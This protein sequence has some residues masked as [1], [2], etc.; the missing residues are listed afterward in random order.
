MAVAV[1]L[2]V[3]SG[4]SVMLWQQ[5]TR[6]ASRRHLQ[7]GLRAAKLGDMGR[8]AGDCELA[9]QLDR[10][11][12][13]ALYNLG[14]AYVDTGRNY[15]AAGAYLRA[16]CLRPNSPA[17]RIHLGNACT[18]LGDK[19]RAHPRVKDGTSARGTCC[20]TAHQSR[21]CGDEGW[22]HGHRPARFTRSVRTWARQRPRF[23]QPRISLHA[24]RAV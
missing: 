12:L 16:L 13:D 8:A 1:L 20:S 11:N 22:A 2:L 7:E 9:A 3:V 19:T 17:I 6:R 24:T 15:E 10:D 23:L 21:D 18:R 4:S 14:P 5:C